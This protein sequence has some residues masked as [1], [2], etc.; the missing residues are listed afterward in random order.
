MFELIKLPG[1]QSAT[2]LCA[3]AARCNT[4]GSMVVKIVHAERGKAF[5]GEVIV[6]LKDEGAV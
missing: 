6:G 5:K 3:L 2:V 1:Q 4:G